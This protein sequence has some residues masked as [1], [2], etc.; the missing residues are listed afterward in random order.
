M[1]NIIAGLAAIVAA[2]LIFAATRPNTFRIQ[3]STAIQAPPERIFPIINDHHQWE[4]WSPWENLDPAMKKTYSGAGN[5][6]G[7]IYEWQGNNKVGAGRTEITESIQPS[8]IVMKLDYLKP[9][10]AHNTVEFTLEPQAGGTRITWAMFGS[11]P[12]AGKLMGMLFSDR[13]VG[14]MFDDGLTRLKAVA[15]K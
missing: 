6:L 14:R 11:R 8:R 3:R 13:M 1:L 7:A 2:I 15:E 4:A 9:F 5:G 10:E 12:Y